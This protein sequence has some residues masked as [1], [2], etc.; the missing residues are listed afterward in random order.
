MQG[1]RLEGEESGEIW[2]SCRGCGV[3]VIRAVGSKRYG[4]LCFA[5]PP[6]PLMLCCMSVKELASVGP[7]DLEVVQA[8]AACS[9][10]AGYESSSR[11]T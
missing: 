11:A 5:S 8:E 7:S 3:R 9:E 10:M 4:I 1:L 6:L 2:T